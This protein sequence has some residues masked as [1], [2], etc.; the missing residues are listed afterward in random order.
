M[1]ERMQN[2]HNVSRDSDRNLLSGEDMIEFSEVKIEFLKVNDVSDKQ[3][4]KN[5]E[6]GA[7]LKID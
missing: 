5:A 2:K 6:P 3:A 4:A 1:E 7:F